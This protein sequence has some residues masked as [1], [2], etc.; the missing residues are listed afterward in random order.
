MNKELSIL[1]P[2]YNSSENLCNF[3]EELIQIVSKKFKVFEIVMVDDCSKDNSWEKIKTLCSKY[4]N[5]KGIQLRKNVGQHN[6]IFSGLNYCEGEV[7][8]T[9]DDDGQNSPESIADLVLELKKG[10]DVCYA[11]YKVKKHNLFRRFGSFLNNIVASFLFKKPTN[12]ILTSFRCFK[13]DI[14][15]EILNHKSSY[16]YI[17][18]LI[19][20]ITDNVSQIYVDHKERLYGKSNYTIIKLIGLWLKMATGFSVLPLRVASIFGIIFSLTS[21]A[22]IIWITFFRPISSEIPVG[23]TSLVVIIIF[24][25]GIQLLALGLIGEYLGRAYLTLNNSPKYSEKKK[26]NVQSILK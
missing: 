10:Y 12:L 13:K 15:N 8:I 1:I 11:N 21:F 17:D 5:I 16:V 25:G 6:A 19:F 3:I 23:W 22:I 14:K 2:V 7:I 4:E 24:L 26:L 18:G 9:M 20:S